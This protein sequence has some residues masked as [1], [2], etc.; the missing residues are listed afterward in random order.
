MGKKVPERIWVRK[1]DLQNLGSGP[2][3][4]RT[5]E[6]PQLIYWSEFR[7]VVKKAKKKSRVK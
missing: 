1:C 2:V 4:I 3:F 7:R 6:G 5:F